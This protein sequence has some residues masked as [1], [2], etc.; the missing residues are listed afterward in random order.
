MLKHGSLVTL[1]LFTLL[2]Q[3]PSPLR[4]QPVGGQAAPVA[5][6]RGGPSDMTP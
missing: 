6:I 2:L 4:A 3:L 1:A 5:P